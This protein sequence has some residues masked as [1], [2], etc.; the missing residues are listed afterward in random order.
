MSDLISVIV[1]IFNVAP[2]LEKCISSIINQTYK[3]LEIILVDDGSTDGSSDIC[4]QYAKKDNRVIVIHQDNQKLTKTR[5]N[6][7]RVA[8]GS[9]VGFVDGDDWIAPEMYEE[10]YHHAK[11]E[12]AQIVLSGMFRDN[13]DK[14][15]AEWPASIIHKEGLYADESLY[16]LKKNTLTCL[17]G[18]ICN[19]LFEK[20]LFESQL[21]KVDDDLYGIEDD[22]FAHLCILNS[23]KIFISNKSYYHGVERS[24]SATHSKH[25]DYYLMLHRAIPLYR[26]MIEVFP[27]KDFVGKC[28]E[29]FLGKAIM[30]ATHVFD[31]TA[32]LSYYYE[33]DQSCLGKKRVVLYGG[34]VVGESYYTQFVRDG[35][36][37][38]IGW[39][40]KYSKSSKNLHH[41]LQPISLLTKLNYDL[42]ILA[43]VKKG[44]NIEEVKKELVSIGIPIEK[45]E[46]KKP[47][48][49]IEG[50][51][52]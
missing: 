29:M 47:K 10:L 17:N 38:V 27:D 52:K 14:V 34:G 49:V 23:S 26:D 40:D 18:S 37:E 51:I 42:I 30:G 13:N 50:I 43:L 28:K 20:K 11:N 7:V 21:K 48:K 33:Y 5:K 25:R 15:Y 36:Y 8:K 46:W 19:K 45:I 12:G 2:Y 24:D 39:V 9:Y 16:E 6:G 35:F 41:I 32:I 44:D 1:P 31:K 4:D 22:L 3:E